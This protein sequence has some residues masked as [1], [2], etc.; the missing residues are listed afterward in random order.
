[1][2]S[3]S[4]AYAA[5]A[6]VNLFSA[7]SYSVLAGTAVSSVGSN[8]LSGDLGISPGTA[9]SGTPIVVGGATHLGDA[10]AAKAQAD[11]WVAYNNAAGRAPTATIDALVNG[12]ILSPGVYRSAAALNQGGILTLDAQG[13][14]NAVFIFQIGAG[15][16]TAAAGNIKLV[17]GA[18]A[19]NVFWQV[20]AS[21]TLGAS[22]TFSGTILAQTAI[23]VGA[24]TVINGRVLA[25][26]GAISLDSN[27]V[28]TA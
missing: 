28:N 27:I 7:G 24:G 18:K 21:A 14:A 20:G 10:A 8:S 23:T 22:A 9:V 12:Q 4:P 2:S 25:H 13:N 3:A 19:S 16:T 5:T 17:N 15:L 6:P 26:N 11:M 1:M